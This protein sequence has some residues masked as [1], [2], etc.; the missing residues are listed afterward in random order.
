MN[1]FLGFQTQTPVHYPFDGKQTSLT[2]V[3]AF[4]SI[5][6]PHLKGLNTAAGFS[7]VFMEKD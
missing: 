1:S 7:L 4:R 6:G 2:V 3:F 5:S